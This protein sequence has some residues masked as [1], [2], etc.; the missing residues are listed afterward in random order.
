[1]DNILFSKVFNN[2]FLQNLIF[3]E[4]SVISSPQSNRKA[5]LEKMGVF[6]CAIARGT[7]EMLEYLLEFYKIDRHLENESPFDRVLNRF[8]VFAAQYGR[9]DMVEYLFQRFPDNQSQWELNRALSLSVY[10]GNFELLKFISAKLDSCGE[11]VNKIDNKMFGGNVYNDAAHLG[12]IDIIKWLLENR[13]QDLARTNMII[14]ATQGNQPKVI[15]FLL[16]ELNYP[17]NMESRDYLRIAA[18]APDRT[19]IFKMLYQRKCVCPVNAMNE[20][21]AFG[22]LELIKWLHENT[23]IGCT[24]DAMTNAAEMGHLETVKWLHANRTEG[25]NEDTMDLAAGQNHLEIV[26]WLHAN[27]NEGCTE[28]AFYNAISA[29]HLNMLKW[30]HKNKNEE[31]NPS[32]EMLDHVAQLGFVEMLQWLEETTG[33]QCSESALIEALATSLPMVKYLYSRNGPDNLYGFNEQIFDIAVGSLHLGNVK[34]LHENLTG[35]E[36]ARTF[37]LQSF[38]RALQSNAY[39]LVDFLAEKESEQCKTHLK[40]MNIDDLIKYLL[41][42]NSCYTLEWVL[43]NATTLSIDQLQQHQKSVSTLN[44]IEAIDVLTL[45]I[46][47]LSLSTK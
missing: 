2:L 14:C 20:A 11:E 40:S 43:Q 19:E 45:H 47:S 29:N 12:R 9:L 22:N 13:S 39:E 34:W 16:D 37:S 17:M 36:D 44:S 18:R 46:D 10:S 6:E 4:V 21:S 32:V 26:K 24:E 15:E 23:T 33:L 31:F 41:K 38:G 35:I 5:R 3:K 25:C 27:R 28:N 1:M 42:N 7:T 8:L 30:L